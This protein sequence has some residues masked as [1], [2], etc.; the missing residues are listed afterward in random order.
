MKKT[1]LSTA[2]AIASILP[3]STGAQVVCTDVNPDVINSGNASLDIDLNNDNTA[4]FRITSA[5]VST[6]SFVVVQGSQIGTSNFV[7]TNGSGGALALA[8][9]AP[10]SSTSTTWTQ[11]NATNMQMIMVAG[12]SVSGPWAGASDQ[13][14]G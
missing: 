3:L 2:F 11:M 10:I 8:L 13:Y 12:S 9:N 4:D 5:Q 1:L 14:L 6:L 7:L